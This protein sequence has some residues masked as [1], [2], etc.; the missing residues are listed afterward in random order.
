MKKTTVIVKRKS[1]KENFDERKLYASIYSAC[2]SA[3]QKKEQ[4]EKIADKISKKII[5]LIKNKKE[6]SSAELR[7]QIEKELKKIDEELA[8]FYEHNLPNLKKL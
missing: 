4:C 8:F 5:K 7:K 1:H 3:H 6:I 2:A